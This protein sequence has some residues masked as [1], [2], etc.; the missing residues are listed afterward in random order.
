LL[1]S[2]P[3]AALLLPNSGASPNA[4][5]TNT[6]YDIILVVALLVFV[7]VEGALVFALFRYRARR[8]AAG[9]AGAQIR[10]NTRLQ[11]SVAAAAGLVLLALFVVTLVK[12]PSIEDPPNSLP[13][14]AALAGSSGGVLYASDSRR[15]P[16]SG[17]SLQIT[18]VGRQYLWQY[19]YPDASLPDGLG[20]PYSYEELV[21]PTETTVT[22]DV[23]SEDVVHSWWVPA[24]GGKVD[25][26]PGYHGYTWFRAER[27]GLYR[28]QCAVM[29]GR[30]HARMIAR[31]RALSPAAFS[32]WLAKQR[33]LL[34]EAKTA[35][36]AERA[37]L[38]KGQS[39]PGR[40]ENP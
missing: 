23:V 3:T 17:K 7:L 36:A 25:A 29:C 35:A 8:S 6:L 21:V 22:L 37:V 27:P 30:G 4:S 11:L 15:L 33:S 5:A 19:F 32:A 28:G 13:G 2:L 24:L 9:A 10:G 20:A 26:V 39:G 18:V 12:L 16:P 14:G 38:M 31:V 34:E 1:S 40:V